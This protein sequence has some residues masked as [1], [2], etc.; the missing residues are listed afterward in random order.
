MATDREKA[1][2]ASSIAAIVAIAAVLLLF[3]VIVFRGCHQEGPGIQDANPPS[4]P[5]P[6]SERVGEAP[7]LLDAAPLLA[8]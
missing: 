4:E 3:V 8:A 6:G 7:P 5:L 1:S 2:N